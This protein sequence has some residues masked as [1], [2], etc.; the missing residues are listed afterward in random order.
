MHGPACMSVEAIDVVTADGELRPRRARARTPTCSGRRAARARLLRRSSRAFTCACSRRP[1][2][3][4]TAST[5]TRSTCSRR[6]SVGARDRARVI[7]RNMELMLIV[8]RDEAGRAGDR[9]H[10][11]R[12]GRRRARGA[13]GAR[14]A[15]RRA[16]WLAARA[17]RCRN[18]A[19]PL[20]DLYARRPRVLPRRAPLRRRQHVD[21]RAGRRAAARPR[22]RIA[23]T[24]PERPRTCCG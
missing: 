16:P 21:A 20:E 18:V 10:R 22:A 9:R 1:R 11:A 7:P 17:P 3:S 13:R 4:P 23:E 5:S 24:L 12:A 6:S 15:R 8:H 14:A 19:R 2:S